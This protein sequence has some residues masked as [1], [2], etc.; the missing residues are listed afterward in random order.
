MLRLAYLTA[1]VLLI[2]CGEAASPTLFVTSERT[3]GGGS[4]GRF[5]V[6]R[7]GLLSK[8]SDGMVAGPTT[9]QHLVV[10]EITDKGV[11]LTFATVDE[12]GA[13]AIE[14]VFVSYGEETTITTQDDTTWTAHLER[15]R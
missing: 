3:D 4:K 1:C 14:Q 15:N 12:S 9:E 2:G 5:L 13:Q 11:M 7:T 10:D 8:T 6:Q